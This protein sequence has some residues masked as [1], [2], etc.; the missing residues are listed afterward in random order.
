MAKAGGS[1]NT[2]GATR[3]VYVIGLL[4]WLA[5]AVIAL[6]VLGAAALGFAGGDQFGAA[7]S[8]LVLVYG[9]VAAVIVYVAMGWLQQSLLMLVG[10][11]KNTAKDDFLSRL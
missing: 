5:L 2:G 11:A 7:V 1:V 6:G 9:I 3:L 10:I 4:K 8:L